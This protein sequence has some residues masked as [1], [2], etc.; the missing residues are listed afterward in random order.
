M[1]LSHVPSGLLP[2]NWRGHEVRAGAIDD[3]PTRRSKG[4]E[5]L[6]LKEQLPH[7]IKEMTERL[8]TLLQ[9]NTC[10]NHSYIFRF[11]HERPF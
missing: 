3:V 4:S 6:A 8:G 2:P 7:S 9:E 10:R 11:W 5:D 1:S